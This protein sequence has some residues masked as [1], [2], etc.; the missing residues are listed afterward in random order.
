MAYFIV[1]RHAD[2]KLIIDF[3]TKHPLNTVKYKEFLDFKKAFELYEGASV[4]DIRLKELLDNI[5]SGMNKQRTDFTLRDQ[6]YV[7]TP[8]WLLGFVEGDGS[9]S[10]IKK[11]YLVRFSLSQSA[12]DLVLL[13]R[14]QEF[15]HK[16]A[17]DSDVVIKGIDNIMD[18]IKIYSYKGSSNQVLYNL[19]IAHSDFLKYVLIPFF[20]SLIFLTPSAPAGPQARRGKKKLDYKDWKAV[21]KLK[22][23]GHHYSEEGREIIEWI[24]SQINN[25]RLTSSRISS[26]HTEGEASLFKVR[27]DKLLSGS[28]NFEVK[29]DGR[30][31]IK[32][33]K[34]YYTSGK[35]IGVQ[36]QD[37]NSE[38]VINSF[39]SLTECAKFLGMSLST[40]HRR[41]RRNEPVLFEN[42]QY[43]VKV[44]G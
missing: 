12:K 43:Y 35:T 19:Q 3:F 41:I 10:I 2:L 38:T 5:R 36:L 16:L 27:L 17:I 11:N 28:S 34:K 15:L 6:D 33:L 1:S 21:L 24:L 20:D 26:P 25:N 7:I 29:E 31:F 44:V 13:E 40:L 30:I 4:K 9:F 42:R 39:V 8:Y 32:S 14:I 22:E 23:E 37:V 18:L